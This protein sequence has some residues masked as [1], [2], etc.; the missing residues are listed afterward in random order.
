[1]T[2]TAAP[3]HTNPIP[4][5]VAAQIARSNELIAAAAAA[6]AAPDAT[7][8]AASVTETPVTETP[9]DAQTPGFEAPVTQPGND[10]SFEQKF[11][12]EQGRTKALRDEL[13]KLRQELSA[14]V[15]QLQTYQNRTAPELTFD[16]GKRLI[17]PEEETEYGQEF[18]DLVGR[19]AQEIAAPLQK[20]LT[21][22]KA[23]L[24]GDQAKTKEQARSEMLRD[25]TKQ[26]P[27]WQQI[28]ENE[29]FLNWLEEKDAFSGQIRQNLLT[30]AYNSNETSRVARFFESFLQ[31]VTAVAPQTAAQPDTQKVPLEQLAAPGR[32]K[33]AT[34][35][36]PGQVA[37]KPFIKQSE[38]TRFYTEV[39]AN[40]YRGRDAERKQIEGM[41][42]DAQREGR[43][44]P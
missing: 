2:S 32:A 5:A 22:I 23:K 16:A 42:F 25:L 24:N 19:R 36:A 17:T 6:K 35:I 34:V 30:S 41:I 4:P 13:A 29:D 8:E 3:Q 33:S 38:I 10:Q 39:A 27:N 12:S 40:K 15:A 44:V 31:E 28:N 7:P 21:D 14:T 43:I 11:R 18:M 37:D 9:V 1:M 20:E 26:V